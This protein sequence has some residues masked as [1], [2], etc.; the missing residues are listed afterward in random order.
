MGGMLAAYSIIAARRF[1]L[2]ALGALCFGSIAISN[3]ALAV[4]STVRLMV[5]SEELAPDGV[6]TFRSFDFSSFPHLNDTGDVVFLASLSDQSRGVFRSNGTLRVEIARS[7]Q[8][9]PNGN[10]LLNIINSGAM[11]Q[12]GRFVFLSSL[13]GTSGGTSDNSA[14]FVGDGSLLREV[15]REG[16][17]NPGG[18]GVFDQ[19]TLPLLNNTGDIAF[20]ATLRGTSGGADD[21]QAIFVRRGEELRQSVREGQSA[22]EGDGKLGPI[23][24]LALNELGHIAF[25]GGLTGTIDGTRTNLGMFLNDGTSLRT[26]LRKGDATPTGDA[27]LSP[28]LGQTDLNNHG[29]LLFRSQLS[30]DSG[31]SVSGQGLYRSD[32]TNLVELARSGQPAPDGNGVLVDFPGQFRSALNDAGQALFQ[33]RFTGTS[34]G[35]RDDEGIYRSDGASLVEIVREGQIAPGGGRIFSALQFASP[36]MNELGQVAFQIGLL[37]ELNPNTSPL[38]TAIYLYDDSLG[39]IPVARTGQPLFGSR[40]VRLNSMPTIGGGR[41]SGAFQ[42]VGMSNAGPTRVLYHFLLAD[43]RSGIALW[44]LVPEPGSIAIVAIGALSIGVASNWPLRRRSSRKAGQTG[45]GA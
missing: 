23:T 35:A 26:I 38:E 1:E 7:G 14:I 28:Y 43:G 29:E 21:N 22:P 27:T 41:G 19:L 44:T 15:V 45:N 32:G 3:S 36:V 2:L 9:A 4:E 8:P 10:G 40:V 16:Q 13:T 18:N 30:F 11:D 37:D 20:I 31:Q 42:Q 5:M 34:G 39:L 12:A 17:A 24:P 6:S 25:M 33:A